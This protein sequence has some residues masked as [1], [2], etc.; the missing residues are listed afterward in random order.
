MRIVSKVMNIIST[1]LVVLIALVL[2]AVLALRIFGLEGYKVLSGSMEPEYP[3]GSVIY[4][5]DVDPKELKAGDV[6][7]YYLSGSTI[8]THRIVEV[9]QEKGSL[10]FTTKG[11]ANEQ[12]DSVPVAA[13]DL[14]GTP[15]FAVPYLGYALTY[16]QTT[17]GMYVAIAA[18]AALLLLI[19]LPPLLLPEKREKKKDEQIFKEENQ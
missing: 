15:V 1:V 10:C 7:T 17:R 11:D 18:G 3:T 8:S 2:V 12:P 16:M 6:I 19:M 5:K 9:K 14:I 13:E 4:V